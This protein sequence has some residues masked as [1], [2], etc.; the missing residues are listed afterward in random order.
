[1][2]QPRGQAS[3]AIKRAVAEAWGGCLAG[4]QASTGAARGWIQCAVEAGIAG[5]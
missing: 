5:S 2:L 4:G 3:A 1:M